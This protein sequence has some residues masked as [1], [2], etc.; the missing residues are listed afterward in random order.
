[1]PILYKFFTTHIRQHDY[2]TEITFCE[3]NDCSVC[4]KFRDGL[5]TPTSD[6]VRYTLL[7]PMD[8]P[9]HDPMNVGHFVP[10]GLTTKFI[11]EKKLTFDKLKA[12]LPLLDKKKFI[13][14]VIKADR[15]ADNDVGGSS[16]FKGL[17]VRDIA[18]CNMC[19]FPRNI[20]SFKGLKKRKP[21]LSPNERNDLLDQLESFK[22]SYVCGD[23]CP[24]DGY[25]SK[26]DLRCGD[27][28]EVQ[29]YTFAKKNNNWSKDICCYCLNS[30]ELLTLDEMK[31]TFNTGGKQPLPLCTYCVSLNVK[32]PTTNASTRFTE[33]SIQ[34]KRCKKRMRDNTH[35][36]LMR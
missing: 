33:K 32:P 1:M 34:E 8:R 2:L 16:L 5:R 4:R 15:K 19:S 11:L 26:R 22:D 12:E 7:R 25:E 6:L 9:V 3:D 27:F 14:N 18:K 24:V 20:Y 36:L 35:K 23:V 31:Q 30:D 17:N 29:Y 28:V 21:K 10:A 13:S